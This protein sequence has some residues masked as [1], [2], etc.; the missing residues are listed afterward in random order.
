MNLRRASLLTV[1]LVIGALVLVVALMDWNW[2]RGPAQ[3]L[4]SS[5][6]Q[7]E[8]SLG[9]LEVR[10]GL[11]SVVRLRDVRMANTDWSQVQPMATVR[12]IEFSIRLGSMLMPP[13][14]LPHV[15][16]TDADVLLERLA[17]GRS[18]WEFGRGG[19]QGEDDGDRPPALDLRGLRIDGGRLAYRDEQ[20]KIRADARAQT[21]NEARYPTWVEFSGDWRGAPF[22]GVVR[23]GSVLSVM[24]SNQPFALKLSMKASDTTLEA[25]GEITD[26]ATWGGIDAQL[27]IAGPSL[28]S[29]YPTLRLALPAS[30]PYRFDGRLSKRGNTYGYA[31]FSGT[32]GGSDIAGDGELVIE[33]PRPRLTASLRSKR[34]NLDDLGPLIGVQAAEAARS[35][36]ARPEQATPGER[37]QGMRP[38]ESKSRP[39]AKK[40]HGIERLDR[41]ISATLRFTDASAPALRPAPS[42][43]PLLHL[44]STPHSPRSWMPPPRSEE[45]TSDDAPPKS[46]APPAKR[47]SA[48][49]RA[50]PARDRSPS[51]TPPKQ[52]GAAL[53]GDAPS[54]RAAAKQTA[55]RV[56]ADDASSS[57]VL[58]TA[59]FSGERLAVID[60]D[61][62]Y[63]IETLRLPVQQ[64]VLRDMR[65]RA[66]LQDAELRIDPLRFR[67][68]GGEALGSIVLDG[69]ATPN[70]LRAA[71]DLRRLQLAQLVEPV[72][73]LKQS[74]GRLGA[75]LRLEGRG[76]SVADLL[77][78]ANGTITLGMAGGQISHLVLAAASLNGGRL[79]QLA[80]GGDQP[81]KIRCAGVALNI[82]NGIG[83]INPLVFD[84]EHVRIDGDGQLNFKQERFAL[85]LRP[86]PKKPHIL[87]VRGPLHVRGSFSDVDISLDSSVAA[88]AGAAAALALVNP[89]AALI[90]LIETGGGEDSHCGEVLAPVAGAAQQA[91]SGSTEVPEAETAAQGDGA[92]EGK[93]NAEKR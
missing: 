67:F 20:L 62:S 6:L 61:V 10:P 44:V 19:R 27:M 48:P 17:D 53:S 64:L 14:V 73:K 70:R 49:P 40:T 42:Q 15:R 72:D 21:R 54:T 52:A 30:P 11:T 80:L 2:L 60:A 5:I 65:S 43:T 50:G 36:G 3:R 92:K 87:S 8:V 63:T 22:G 88:R 37:R 13:R 46:A 25:E 79:L 51:A 85:E 56:K 38:Q 31:S 84:T 82:D 29:L 93:K 45:S 35:R 83:T 78:S 89:L 68:A 57:R 69:R 12:E 39:P 77:G 16:L 76:A 28:A 23:T 91:K 59:D 1:A 41:D 90:P 4:A 33:E 81:S 55:E 24:N 86:Q 71:A 18:N 7:R 75:Q 74:G 66:L 26:I 47:Q 9:H 32:V 58:P 34:V